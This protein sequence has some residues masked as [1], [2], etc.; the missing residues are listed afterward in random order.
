M[1]EPDLF[2][3]F[4]ERLK[5]AH[6]DY[7]VTGSV[8]AIVYGEP[9]L[10]NDIDL[11]LNLNKADIPKISQAF[12]S[13]QF[14]CPPKEVIL[15]ELGRYNRGHFKLIHHRTGFKADIY[16][17]GFDSL[18][19]WAFENKR[20]IKYQN[21]EIAIAPAEYV[22]LRKLEFFKEGGS[23]K[24]LYD[25]EGI[26]QNSSALIDFDFLKDQAQKSGVQDILQQ[27]LDKI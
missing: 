15:N 22:I 27:I 16:L 26:L 25:I 7:I 3:I 24:H 19:K 20:I 23:Q 18:H 14:Y 11:I 13:E 10:T 4:L 12:P 17:I 9:R 2:Q 21:S 8:A 6:L 1:Q 5:N